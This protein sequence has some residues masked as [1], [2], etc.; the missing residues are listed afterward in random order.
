MIDDNGRNV[1][2]VIPVKD[3]RILTPKQVAD[4][5]HAA[6][7]IYMFIKKEDDFSAE[8]EKFTNTFYTIKDAI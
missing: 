2:R 6:L 8:F 5:R 3:K 1:L 4:V 7:Y